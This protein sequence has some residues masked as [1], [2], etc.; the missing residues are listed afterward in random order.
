MSRSDGASQRPVRPA[1]PPSRCLVALADP[2]H[3][4]RI[5]PLRRSMMGASITFGWTVPEGLPFVLGSVSRDGWDG[6]DAEA[7]SSDTNCDQIGS[8]SLTAYPLA[9]GIPSIRRL[10][11]EIPK[12]AA[13]S[14]IRPSSPRPRHSTSS[15]RSAPSP[16][17]CTDPTRC[18]SAGRGEGAAGSRL[19]WG[20][21][22]KEWKGE[23][24]SDAGNGRGP[25]PDL[26]FLIDGSTRISSRSCRAS[27][28]SA[29]ASEVPMQ[30]ARGVCWRI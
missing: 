22:V 21:Q 16:R 7:V 24:K 25:S 30:M 6:W 5:C 8:K 1:V 15:H 29:M 11:D 9:C 2:P 23:S 20:C 3:A 12:E 27:I 10:L 13:S 14:G 28:R 18:L 17:G 26:V 4:F 19:R